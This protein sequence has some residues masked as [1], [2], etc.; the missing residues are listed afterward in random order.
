MPR[1]SIP[2]WIGEHRPRLYRQMTDQ[3]HR[4]FLVGLPS[5][6]KSE[7]G[8]S[9]K[10]GMRVSWQYF[11]DAFDS[12]MVIDETRRV[13]NVA[14]RKSHIDGSTRIRMFINLLTVLARFSDY[15]PFLFRHTAL[16]GS[17]PKYLRTLYSYLNWSS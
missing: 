11:I 9:S 4:P 7:R 8:R 3:V 14:R 10:V 2:V 13:K 15:F 12:L 16:V 5:K 6:R 17:H 1:F